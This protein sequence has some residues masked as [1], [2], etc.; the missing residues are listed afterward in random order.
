MKLLKLKE[1]KIE[2]LFSNLSSVTCSGCGERPY[3]K[4][5][6]Q[7]KQSAT[8]FFFLFAQ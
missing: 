5:C 8:E 7:G 4:G 6:Q 3:F 2:A 1:S